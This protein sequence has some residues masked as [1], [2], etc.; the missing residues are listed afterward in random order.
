MPGRDM[1]A[2]AG[3]THLGSADAAMLAE[4]VDALRA[5]FGQPRLYPN[6]CTGSTAYTALSKAFEE[7]VQ[8]CPAGTVL[9]F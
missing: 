3:G 7:K 9:A 6:H 5:G 2:V 4:A 8:P 1:I